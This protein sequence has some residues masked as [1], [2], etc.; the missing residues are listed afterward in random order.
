MLVIKVRPKMYLGDCK[1]IGHI[2]TE[3]FVFN[4]DYSDE[5]IIGFKDKDEYM[6]LR[7]TVRPNLEIFLA[8]DYK[9]SERSNYFKKKPLGKMI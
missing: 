9:A 8:V 5:S 4:E 6:T 7:K 1:S 2:P 3:G